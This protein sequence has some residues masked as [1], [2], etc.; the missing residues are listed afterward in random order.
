MARRCF[1]GV[2]FCP[3]PRAPSRRRMRRND[4]PRA[5]SVCLSV[6]PSLS[7]SFFSFVLLLR[8]VEEERTLHVRRWRRRVYLSSILF[9]RVF[10]CVCPAM[11]PEEKCVAWRGFSSAHRRE[12]RRLPRLSQRSLLG[13]PVEA[14][15][16]IAPKNSLFLPLSLG[17]VEDFCSTCEDAPQPREVALCS[18]SRSLVPSL[19]LLLPLSLPCLSPLGRVRVAGEDVANVQ[20]RTRRR[21]RG[22]NAG[23]FEGC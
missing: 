2:L 20:E 22:K 7:F 19:L 23:F 15:K 16:T 10:V 21:R 13:K 17:R 14:K 8:F 11:L 9:S 1:F 3:P 4:E 18:L 12:S 5:L 6:P